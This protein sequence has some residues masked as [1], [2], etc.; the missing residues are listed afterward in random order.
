MLKEYVKPYKARIVKNAVIKT[1]GTLLEVVLPTILAFIIDTVTPAGDSSRIV[2]WGCVMVVAAVSAWILNI[3][4]NRMASRTASLAIQRIRQDLFSRSLRLSAR[5]LDEL[6]VSSLES[7]LTS[8]TYVVHRFLSATLRMGIRSLLLFLGGVFFCFYLSWR[9]ALVLVILIFPLFFAVRYVFSRARPK[10][11]LV[12]V[13]VDAMVQVIRENIRG[14]KVS[15]ALGKT[16]YEQRRYEAVNNEVREAEIRAID[17]IAMMS[18]IVNVL[19]FSGLAVVLV[20]GAFLSEHDLVQA[21]TIIAFMSYFI[22]ITNSL[23]G[24]NRMFNIYNRSVA[25]TARIEEVLDMPLDGNQH[26]SA[27]AI[28]V[29]PPPGPDVPE[30]EFRN[31]SFSYLGKRN[32]IENISFAVYP[33]QTLG[34]MGATGSGKSTL[35][36]LLLRQYD[37]TGGDILLRGIPIEKISEHAL[38]AMFGI[39]FQNDF[40]FADTVRANIDFGRNLSDSELIR[41]STHAQAIQFI[42]EKEGGLDFTLASKGVNLSG[43]QK[44][45]LLISRALAG[46]SDILLLDDAVSAL[47][48]KTEAD[49]RQA[50]ERHYPVTSIIV[51][52]RIS[53]VRHADTILFL[54]KGRMLAQ[55]NHDRLVRVCEPYMQIAEMQL[56]EAS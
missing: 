37:A 9:L 22:Q 27:D 45:R 17:Q 46:S 47:D 26:V 18:P 53:S 52:Q 5:Q 23:L 3:V 40:L 28:D 25:S 44:Q 21:G 55:G 56:G 24:L 6:S 7:R 42:E 4:A 10:F 36:R 14:I 19:L 2:F 32:D 50:L 39:V 20:Y 15:K 12:Q 30:I 43:G 33:G 38:N 29:L 13:K 35:I 49:F 11:R 16:E 41:A 8:D 34:I 48:F 51:A 54:D 1:S 31:V